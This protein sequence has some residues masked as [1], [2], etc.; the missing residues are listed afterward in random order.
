M[1]G[2]PTAAKSRKP[3]PKSKAKEPVKSWLQEDRELT[4]RRQKDRSI[5]SSWRAPWRVKCYEATIEALGRTISEVP[6]VKDSTIAMMQAIA[7]LPRLTP[8]QKDAL[9]DVCFAAIRAE[10][11]AMADAWLDSQGYVALDHVLGR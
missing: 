3:A 11:D 9:E 6:A 2:K 10:R 4:E 5:R 7:A 8:K 1:S